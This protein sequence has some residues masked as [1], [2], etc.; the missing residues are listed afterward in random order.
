MFQRLFT[1]FLRL[2]PGLV[3]DERDMTDRLN[4]GRELLQLVQVITRTEARL[5]SETGP[6]T[7]G[8][9]GTLDEAKDTEE[10][11]PEAVDF[12]YRVRV[13]KGKGKTAVKT[14][15]PYASPGELLRQAQASDESFLKKGCYPIP[16]DSIDIRDLKAYARRRLLRVYV[17]SACDCTVCCDL[18]KR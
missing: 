15:Q 4:Q 14:S 6:S 11:A 5:L 3:D 8:R 2:P 9:E 18:G 1:F 13:K 10:N 7:A 17:V 16:K 12:G